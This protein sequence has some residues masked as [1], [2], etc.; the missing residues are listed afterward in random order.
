LGHRRIDL[1]AFVALG[2]ARASGAFLPC[3]LVRG[4]QTLGRAAP[5]LARLAGEGATLA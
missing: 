2:V 3:A 5:E 4:R 1:N